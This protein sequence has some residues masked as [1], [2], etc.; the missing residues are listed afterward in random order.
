MQLWFDH[1]MHLRS[2][3]FHNRIS[4]QAKKD[5]VHPDF[6]PDCGKRFLIQIS[7]FIDDLN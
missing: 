6:K 7:S 1:L 5:F 4:H 2:I 3:I